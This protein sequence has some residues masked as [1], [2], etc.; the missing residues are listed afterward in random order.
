MGEKRWLE[1]MPSHNLT[2]FE[3]KLLRKSAFLVM[4]KI[5]FKFRENQN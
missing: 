5:E 3:Y 2:T 1:G 4:A